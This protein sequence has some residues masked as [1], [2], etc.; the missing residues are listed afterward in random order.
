MI[1]SENRYRICDLYESLTGLIPNL[2]FQ[3]DSG[4]WVKSVLTH[5][6]VT[7]SL[8]GRYRVS[9]LSDPYCCPICQAEDCNPKYY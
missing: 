6:K 1:N 4:E 5:G 2:E 7:R 8:F 3:L 9:I